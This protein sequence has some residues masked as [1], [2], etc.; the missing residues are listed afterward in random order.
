MNFPSNR[1]PTAYMGLQANSHGMFS[2]R[3]DRIGSIMVF[4]S[5]MR[6]IHPMRGDKGASVAF[7]FDFGS[8][9]P[10]LAATKPR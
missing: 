9:M 5:F 3:F 2:L 4:R 8:A 1:L 10:Q 6:P 7:G